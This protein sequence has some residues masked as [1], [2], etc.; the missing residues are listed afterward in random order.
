MADLFPVNDTKNSIPS[1]PNSI[2]ETFGFGVSVKTFVSVHHYIPTLALCSLHKP[3][4][5][6]KIIF[7][8]G[9]G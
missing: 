9:H 1:Y 3:L 8:E 5:Y 2:T 4:S 6:N 7:D